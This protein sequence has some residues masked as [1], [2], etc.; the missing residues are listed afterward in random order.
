MTDAEFDEIAPVYDETRG[1]LDDETSTG[2]KEMLEK[3]GCH[4]ILEIGIG[5]GRVA[6]PLIKDDFQVT[7]V[8]LS[9]KMMERASKKGVKNL[10]LAEGSREPFKN[11]SFDATMMA[12]VFHIMQDPISV[13]HESARVSKIGVFAL[14][15]KDGMGRWWGYFRLGL[16]GNGWDVPDSEDSAIDDRTRKYLEERRNAF[17]AIAEKYGWS[18]EK[19]RQL[20]PRNWQ[21]EQE[22]LVRYPPDDLMTVSDIEVT[23]NLEDRLARFEKNA[24]SYTLGMP[25]EMRQEII[26]EIRTNAAKFPER[27]SQ[28]RHVVYQLAMWRPET[29][30]A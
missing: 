18:L 13:L 1:V 25:E 26:G 28:S 21:R 12:H 19:Q 23:P 5:T 29:L 14:V 10:V 15:R 6:L 24:Y 8:D 9:R 3:H 16:S 4:S 11:K 7:G 17:R 2:I 22:I 20:H 30:K 27:A